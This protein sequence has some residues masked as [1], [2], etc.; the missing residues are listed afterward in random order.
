MQAQHAT[1]L[2]W[3][4][5]GWWKGA[6]LWYVWKWI[7]NMKYLIELYFVIDVKRNIYNHIY[8]YTYT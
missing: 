4:V 1:L 7:C 3:V 6:V 8:I 2:V 5:D